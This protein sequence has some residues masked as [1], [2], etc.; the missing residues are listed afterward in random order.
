L[1]LTSPTYGQY[2]ALPTASEWAIEDLSFDV[3]DWLAQAVGD[4]LG[5]DEANDIVRGDGTAKI[6]GFLDTAPSTAGDDASPARDPDSLQYIAGSANIIDDLADLV[7]AVK[8]GYRVGP[9][10]GWVVHPTALASIRKAQRA[11]GLPITEGLLLGYPC[12]ETEAMDEPGQSPPA[13]PVA[14]GNWR[15]GLIIAD[16][17][18]LRVSTDEITLPGFKRFNVRRRVGGRVHDNRAVKLL[19]I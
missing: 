2:S 12:L 4:K 7:A 8:P 19:S 13:F 14:F 5:A 6:T 18:D 11:G 17:T 9:N 10:V 1:R 16:R 3:V 15:R